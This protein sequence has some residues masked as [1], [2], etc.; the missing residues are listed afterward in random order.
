M[1]TVAVAEKTIGTM[2]EETGSRIAAAT[3]MIP[4]LNPDLIPDR[5]ETAGKPADVKK[6]TIS[7]NIKAAAIMIER[8]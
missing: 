6:K 4:D 7:N 1:I 5:S 3:A 2:E 8:S